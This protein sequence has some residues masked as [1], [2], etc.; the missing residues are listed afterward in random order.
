MLT[1]KVIFNLAIC[2][3]I[4]VS[5]L[6]ELP[7]M[8]TTAEFLKKPVSWLSR[9]WSFNLSGDLC[10]WS[11]RSIDGIPI[12]IAQSPSEV[13]HKNCDLRPCILHR[14]RRS[15]PLHNL[16]PAVQ[17]GLVHSS[18]HQN[19]HRSTPIPQTTNPIQS[20]TGS[21]CGFLRQ[22]RSGNPNVQ[23]ETPS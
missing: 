20:D 17:L 3:F 7:W 12:P 11:P 5:L 4:Q 8:L 19:A 18:A 1:M 14:L 22:L 23:R 10:W 16:Q 13:G 6:Y 9:P 15:R 21:L 2:T